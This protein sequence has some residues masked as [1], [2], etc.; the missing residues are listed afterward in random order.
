MITVDGARGPHRRPCQRPARLRQGAADLRRRLPAQHDRLRRLSSRSFSEI[1]GEDWPVVLV[2]LRGRGRSS[3]RALAVDYVSPNDARDLDAVA[4][5]LAIESAV[6]LGQGYGGQVIMMLAAARPR[7]I[8]GTVLIDA[9]P[10]NDPRG[11]VRLRTNL[12]ELETLARRGRVPPD[13]AAD[14][15]GRLPRTRRSEKLDALALRTH[16]IDAKGRVAPLFDRRLIEPPRSVRSR[17]RADP[18]M[19]AVQG[20][21]PCADAADAQPVHRAAPAHD[22]RGDAGADGATPR[23]TRS[24]CRARLPSSTAPTT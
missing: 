10:V 12:K 2:D 16:F 4:T 3:D 19:A 11:L 17:R 21:G 6:M 7:L 1:A 9:G 8:A 15:R 23:A 13:R 14:P 18:A 20:A 24:R 5:A 22:L